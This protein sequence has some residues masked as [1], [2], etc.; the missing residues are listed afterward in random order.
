MDRAYDLVI[1]NGLVAQIGTTAE[2]IGSAP[3][4]EIR[5]REN[6]EDVVVTTDEPTRLLAEITGAA[7]AEGRELEGLEVRR[8][9]LEDIYL[10]LT[11]DAPA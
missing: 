3:K 8:P 6:G 11:R 1:R 9:T 10:D 4:V 5:Y 2:L 7:A